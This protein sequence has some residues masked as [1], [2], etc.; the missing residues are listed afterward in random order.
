MKHAAVPHAASVFTQGMHR[1]SVTQCSACV[2]T[3]W[4]LQIILE[5]P[6]FGQNNTNNKDKDNL[7]TTVNHTHFGVQTIKGAVCNFFVR[8]LTRFQYLIYH[9]WGA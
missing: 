1:Q 8:V 2:M 5:V 7:F 4:T 9:T 6:C 3:S